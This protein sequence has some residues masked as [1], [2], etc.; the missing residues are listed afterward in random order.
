MSSRS[1]R[2]RSPS[3][4]GGVGER[5]AAPGADL[6]LGGDQLAH[7]VRLE[8]RS[9]RRVL[10][11][12]EAVDEVERLGIEERE[13]L[14]DGD[15]EV[16]HGVERL[17]REREHLLVAE[18]LL[19]AHARKPT[20]GIG[21]RATGRSSNRAATTPSSS[22]VRP[23][24]GRQG[25]VLPG[26]R[27]GARG[28]PRGARAGP[29]LARGKE[30]SGPSRARPPRRSRPQPRRGPSVPRR[31]AAAGG[32]GLGRDHPERLGE[33][34][35]HDGDVAERQQVPQVAVLERAGE[36]RRR[37][38]RA[39]RAARGSPRSRPR[40]RARRVP[41]APRAAPG[42]PCSRSA[43]RSRRP[44]ARSCA[45]KRAKRSALPSSGSRSSR[46]PG[47]GG[48]ARASS[49]SPAS[50]STRGSGRNTPTS[51]P[52]GTISTRS[53]WPTT[54]SSTVRMCSEPA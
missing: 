3:E 47:F 10:E 14:L 39:P 15:R 20:H 16:R 45:K 27:G 28:S 21:A 43:S 46:F 6:D 22:A 44:S 25:R 52:G 34:R 24:G 31:R 38:E 32:R 50:A 42:R 5:V 53:T 41:R 8:L 36:E 7:E 9:L 51:T 4:L 40:R 30:R 1:C 17:A 26:A 18:P 19:L 48:S 33:D 49:S 37:G 13:L 11:F 29:R 2:R 35:R 54:S 23:P 12:L